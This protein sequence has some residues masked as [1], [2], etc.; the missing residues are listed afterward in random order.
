MSQIVQPALYSCSFCEK[1]FC[2]LVSKKQLNSCE[3]YPHVTFSRLGSCVIIH[4]VF[5]FAQ[6]NS[7]RIINDILLIPTET[8]TTATSPILLKWDPKSLEIRTLAVERLLEPLVTQ[9]KPI[10]CICFSF[11]RKILLLRWKSCL[12]NYIVPNTSR[13]PKRT[14]L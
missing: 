14:F 2:C 4:S 6:L 8:M 13:I 5:S 3:H 11:Q 12:H 9:V 10:K 7:F 1:C